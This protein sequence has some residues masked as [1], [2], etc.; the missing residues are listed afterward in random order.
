M[1]CAPATTYRPVRR[2]CCARWGA[3]PCRSLRRG[4]AMRESSS[5]GAFAHGFR[6]SARLAAGVGWSARG[7]SGYT[8]G[9]CS[10]R[11]GASPGS[12][13]TGWLRTRPDGRTP[14]TPFGAWPRCPPHSGPSAW[15]QHSFQTGDSDDDPMFGAVP[16]VGGDRPR[17]RPPGVGVARG[18]D[19]HV[20]AGHLQPP[21]VLPGSPGALGQGGAPATPQWGRRSGGAVRATHRTRQGPDHD[22]ALPGRRGGRLTLAVVPRLLGRGFHQPGRR[23]DGAHPGAGVGRQPPG[24]ALK[25][26]AGAD[27]VPPPRLELFAFFSPHIVA[28][29]SATHAA[30]ALGAG[31]VVLAYLR[32]RGLAR[33]ATLALVE[34]D[35]TR[36]KATV[37]DPLIAGFR[38]EATNTEFKVAPGDQPSARAILLHMFLEARSQW[39]AWSASK[40]AALSR[41]RPRRRPQRR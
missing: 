8:T 41:G 22:L 38:D 27:L 33:T 37:V 21:G 7:P 12:T 17:T 34:P 26:S 4:R 28:G 29:M 19:G 20:C 35:E 30:Q 13:S 14:M 15:A 10:W 11:C 9:G 6:A 18:P 5:S 1:N 24:P 16:V 23:R 39:D 36:F 32:A 31:E 40:A 25:P 2:T 3:T